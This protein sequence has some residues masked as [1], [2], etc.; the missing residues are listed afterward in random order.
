MH[1]APK[2][3]HEA[4]DEKLIENIGSKLHDSWRIDSFIKGECKKKVRAE[5]QEKLGTDSEAE[6]GKAFDEEFEVAWKRGLKD[7][8]HDFISTLKRIKSTAD[9]NWA[10]P[11]IEEGEKPKWKEK[12]RQLQKGDQGY[13]PNVRK[14]EVD[15]LTDFAS[16]PENWR[17]D[18][19]EA[20]KIVVSLVTEE[21]NSMG[22]DATFGA[23]FT[24]LASEAIHDAFLDR[25]RKTGEPIDPN[26]DKPYADLTEEEKD[27][28]RRQVAV[29]IQYMREAGLING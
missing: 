17:E 6:F 23:E 29:A 4:Y 12:P 7:E 27:K 19:F 3:T 22:E 25:R 8:M 26:Q 1:E 14:W 13:D 9:S 16:L 21:I 18:N 24:E 20:A 15:I 28:D 2:N 11:K 10:E 5:W